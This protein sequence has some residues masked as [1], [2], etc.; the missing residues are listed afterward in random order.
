MRKQSTPRPFNAL[1]EGDPIDPIRVRFEES[2]EH[3]TTYIIAEKVGDKWQ[4]F[5]RDAWE[6]RWYDTMPTS[7][8]VKK[9]EALLKS[10]K[11]IAQR[12][13]KLFPRGVK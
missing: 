8:R 5:E 13:V 4:F 6:V 2:D 10:A 11:P 7:E 3:T 9:A 1:A 12:V